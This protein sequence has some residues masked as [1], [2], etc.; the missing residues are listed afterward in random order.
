[1]KK[2]FRDWKRITSI[3][4]CEAPMTSEKCRSQSETGKES[5]PSYST[6]ILDYVKLQWRQRNAEANQRLDTN[7][8]HPIL[9]VFW[10]MWSSND[11]R[12]MEK[13]FRD[14]KIFRV[15]LLW[16][17]PLPKKRI[18]IIW[19]TSSNEKDN[20]KRGSEYRTKIILCW[21]SVA[22]FVAVLIICIFN[23]L[24]ARKQA[25]L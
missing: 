11:V 10:T 23:T 12:E 1:M 18:V 25:P 16:P 8:I 4:L 14:R 22:W 2:P 13:P 24:L 21:F 19:R 17:K 6:C 5:H 3:L 15:R 20:N 9:P 7:H